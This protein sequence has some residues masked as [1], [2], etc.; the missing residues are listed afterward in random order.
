MENFIISRIQS[1]ID[2]IQVLKKHSLQNRRVHSALETSIS[3]CLKQYGPFS[4]SF[5]FQ[6]KDLVVFWGTQSGTA[7]VL[8]KSLAR[9]ATARF[10]IKSMAA[11]LDDYDHSHLADFPRGKF[12]IFILA[13]YGEGDPPDNTLDF[14][15]VL[16]QLRCQ[17][18]GEKILE[19][20]RF[21]TFGL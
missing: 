17:E 11:D 15:S 4:V 20:L 10:N 13:T 3:K 8:A 6:D 18:Q 9:E 7:K 5:S 1:S 12:A 19:K 2:G 16:G 14:C 21:A